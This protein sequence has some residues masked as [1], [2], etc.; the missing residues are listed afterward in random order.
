MENLQQFRRQTPQPGEW[1]R[2]DKNEKKYQVLAV[3][4]N[5]RMAV[6]KHSATNAN[7]SLYLP[8]GPQVVYWDRDDVYYRSLDEFMGTRW[9]GTAYVF[10]FAKVV[11]E[12]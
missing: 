4:E 1:W 10:R 9:D 3:V 5:P 8:Y 12:G 11:T 2:N 7:N 6:E